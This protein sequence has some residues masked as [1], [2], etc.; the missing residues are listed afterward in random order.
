MYNGSPDKKSQRPRRSRYDIHQVQRLDRLRDQS[1]SVMLAAPAPVPTVYAVLLPIDRMT[2]S[3][4][5]TSVSSSGLIV[6][7]VDAAPAGIVTVAGMASQSVPLVAV[8]L[9]TMLTVSGALPTA[10]RVM[11]KTAVSPAASV[12]VASVMLNRTS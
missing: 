2:V 8:P 1:L 12:A 3:L 9:M 4:P 5:S 10:T 11:V 6:T 7:V